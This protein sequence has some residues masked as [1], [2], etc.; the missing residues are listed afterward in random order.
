MTYNGWSSYETWLTNIH[1]ENWDFSEYTEQIADT[2][3]QDE[4]DVRN[5][6]EDYIRESV[7]DLTMDLLDTWNNPWISDLAMAAFSEIDF[8]DLADH[9]SGDVW[10]EVQQLKTTRE[11]QEHLKV[12]NE[13]TF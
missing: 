13:G 2:D 6:L 9:Y 12:L 4:L 8:R 1:F 3:P 5:W 11:H 7:R 10:N